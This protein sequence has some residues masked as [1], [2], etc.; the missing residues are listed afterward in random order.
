AS[1]P[2]SRRGRCRQG[3]RRESRDDAPAIVSAR[4]ILAILASTGSSLVV[5]VALVVVALRVGVEDVTTL[6]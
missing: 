4:A 6:V 5:G 3:R 2:S 1:P